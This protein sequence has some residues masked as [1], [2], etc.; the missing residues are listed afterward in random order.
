MRLSTHTN[1]NISMTSGLITIK[2]YLKHQWDR[3]KT[4]LGFY[5]DRSRTLCPMTT[6]TSHRDIMDKMVSPLFSQLFFIP[7]F[8]YLQLLMEC[9]RPRRSTKFGAIEPPAA[10]L[11]ALEHLKNPHRLTMRKTMSPIFL[12]CF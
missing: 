12:S 7:N 11:A 3:G 8:S 1:I 5:A 9:M 6:D 10:E 4:S 2:F